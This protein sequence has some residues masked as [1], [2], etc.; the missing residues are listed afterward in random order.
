LQ[1]SS[2]GDELP[3]FTDVSLSAGIGV[4]NPTYGNPIWGDFD[5]DGQLDVFVS[6]HASAPSLF[7]NNG[8]GTFTDLR[9]LSG[10]PADG[11]RHGAAWGDY[12]ND[13]KLDLFITDG[14]ERGKGLGHK[15]DQLYRNDGGGAFTDVTGA[16]GVANAFGRGRAVNWVDVNN[17]GHLDL[18]IKNHSSPNALYRNNGDGTFTDV[19][20]SAGIADAP[21]DVSAWADYDG[22]GHIDVAITSAANDQ[23]WKNNGNS[24][25]TEV[26]TKAGL[27]S[28]NRG[29]GIAWGD[30]NNDGRIDLFIARGFQ[31]VNDSLAWDATTIIFSDQEKL[32]ENGLDFISSGTSVTFDLYLQNC[33]HPQRVVVGGQQ[34]SPTSLPVTLT[35]QEATGKPTYTAGEDHGYF[36]WK[37]HDGWHLRWVSKGSTVYLYGKITSNGQFTSVQALNFTRY[38]PTIKSTLYRNN[39]DG[40]FTDVTGLSGVGSPLNNRGAIWGDYDNDGYLDLYIVNSGSFQQNGAKHLLRNNG[41]GT[42]HDVTSTAQVW[43]GV[44]GRGNGAAWGDF[45]NDGFLDLYVTNGWGPPILA[46][47][48]SPKCLVSG[49]HVLYKN[50]G[51]DNQWLKLTLIGKSSNRDAIGSKLVLQAGGLA[52]FREVNGGGGGQFFS[53]G[54]GPIHFGLGQAEVVDALT[55]QWLSGARQ[56]LTAI[57]PNQNLVVIEGSTLP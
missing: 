20:D 54:S 8:S 27:K 53:Q 50:N 43:A 30:Y 52:Q 19:A 56:T 26:T 24:T 7:H 22:D 11:D 46:R 41:D 13:G 5:H 48:G 57:K 2:N 31:D 23:L 17:D 33:R 10:I 51:N 40:T 15:T 45:D 29:Q 12:D 4:S 55:I 35:A 16:A 6:N 18:F 14:A 38:T 42:F 1:A 34:L 3:T 39:G 37:D 9:P 36:I 21:G 44:N 49:P 32:E 25:F 47:K 28:L